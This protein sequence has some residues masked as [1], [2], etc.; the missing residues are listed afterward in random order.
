[1]GA[2]CRALLRTP[3]S[4]ARDRSRPLSRSAAGTGHAL[5]SA[6]FAAE[7]GQLRPRRQLTSHT[8]AVPRARPPESALQGALHLDHVAG[9][10][11]RHPA[12]QRPVVGD[13]REHV[14]RLPRARGSGRRTPSRKVSRF[15]PAR[16]GAD[17]R[18]GG[19]PP[20]S[21]T[22]F[23]S[24]TATLMQRSLV[25]GGGRPRARADLWTGPPVW[26]ARGAVRQTSV[27]GVVRGCP[28]RV[29]AGG[30]VSPSSSATS[31]ST[32]AVEVRPSPWRPR[33][34]S[35]TTSGA[36]ASSLHLAASGSD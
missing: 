29:P 6:V 27:L 9:L 3:L 19:Q 35:A 25:A 16:Q 21:T 23:R 12:L 32:S 22:S 7:R 17:L 34:S 4:D 20:R 8:D 13:A 5:R 1:M 24:I 15:V 36:A 26:T 10:P 14:D 31:A 18:G 33:A 2:R 28:R 30:S 11:Q